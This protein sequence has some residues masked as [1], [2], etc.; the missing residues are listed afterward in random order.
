MLTCLLV[1]I[2]TIW[3]GVTRYGPLAPSAFQLGKYDAFTSTGLPTVSTSKEM[4]LSSV[5]MSL[6]VGGEST[7][8][9]GGSAGAPFTRSHDEGPLA[10]SGTDQRVG[11]AY[12]S[13]AAAS[14]FLPPLGTPFI[15][16]G[17]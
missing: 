4:R 1:G 6:T 8:T 13:T 7:G 16:T 11:S 5:R 10:A 12:Q 17:W 15:T 14:H 9:R 2:T 3:L